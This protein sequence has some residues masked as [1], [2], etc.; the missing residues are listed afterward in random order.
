MQLTLQR[1]MQLMRALILRPVSL[2]T[3]HA[4][5]I[6]PFFNPVD[7]PFEMEVQLQSSIP[8][9]ISL[10]ETLIVAAISST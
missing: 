6:A 7:L 10:P 1:Q 9:V 2:A 3:R 4:A 8:L 5:S